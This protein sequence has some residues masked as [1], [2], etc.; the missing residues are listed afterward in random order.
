MA[1]ARSSNA[2][3]QLAAAGGN[4]LA[5][6]PNGNTLTDASGKQYVYDA[7]DRPV[8]V[9]DASGNVIET[10]RYDAKGERMTESPA[11]GAATDLYYSD[12]GQVIEERQG[13]VTT[14]RNVW[15]ITYVND[16]VVREQSTTT[17]GT[18]DQ[19]RYVQHDANF[20]TTALTDSSGNVVERYQYDPYGAMTVLNADGTVKGDGTYGSSQYHVPTLFQGM[21]LDGV[22]GHYR[23]PNRDYDPAT[24]TWLEA[25]PA[26]YIDGSSRYQFTRSGPAVGD[27]SE[28]ATHVARSR[29]VGRSCS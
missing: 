1:A 18:L 23:T 11:A 10:Y 25:D 29:V 4:T 13:G 26:G 5:Y 14:A 15:G 19:R 20:N 17:P 8:T 7:W 28:R 16:L 21:R 22:T 6:D 3:N 2:R 12:A 9:K 24:G 27:G